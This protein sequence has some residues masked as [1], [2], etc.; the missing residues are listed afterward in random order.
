MSAILG[1]L[2]HATVGTSLFF[3]SSDKIL[4]YAKG[5]VLNS[6]PDVL[7]GFVL[8]IVPCT[9]RAIRGY[10]GGRACFMGVSNA[11]RDQ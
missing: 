4:E 6:S 1:N 2:L 11:E 9:L 10:L 5:V 3:M 8:A 7:K